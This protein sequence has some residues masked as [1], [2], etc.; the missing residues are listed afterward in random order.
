MSNQNPVIW[1][2][3]AAYPV[4]TAA[5]FERSLRRSN[6]VI[7]FGPTI[8]ETL[9]KNWQL[10]NMKVPVKPHDIVTGPTPDIVD[11]LGIAGRENQPDLLLWVE[12]INGFFPENLHKLNIPK[13]CYFIDSHISLA[14]HLDLA[15][16][17]DF[18]FIAQIEYIEEFKKA[19]IENVY[20]LPL[21]CDPEIHSSGS[22]KKLFDVGFV[23]SLGDP[24]ERRYKL[25]KR[26]ESRYQLAYKRCFWDEMSEHF[27]QSKIVFNNAIRNDLNM[28][29]FEV[30]STGSFLLTD[31]A[32]NSGQSEMFYDGQDLSI[33]NDNDILDKI[34]YY[35]RNENLREKIAQRGQQIVHNAHTYTHR[36]E[37]LLKVSLYN[38]KSTPDPLEWR[39][40]SEQNTSISI[41]VNMTQKPQPQRSFVIPVLDM[42]PASPYN[43]VKLLDDLSEIEGDVI[44]IFNSLEMAQKL[45]D[46]PR[47]DYYAVMNENVG[48]S[49][50][51][52]IGLNMSQTPVTF[53]LNSDLHVEKETVEILDNALNEL[54]GAAIVGPQ[55]S[56]FNYDS[57]EDIQ[58]FDKGSFNYPIVVD[59]VSGF[60][61]A[62]KTEYFNSGILKFDNQYTPCYFEEWDLGLQIKLVNLKSYI[63][64]AVGYEHEWSGSIRALRKIRYMKKEETAGEILERNKK[65]FRQ[66]WD[67]LRKELSDKEDIFTSLWVDSLCKKAERLI[68]FNMTADAAKYFKQALNLY[69]DNKNILSS[70]GVLEYK[71]NNLEEALAYFSKVQ[72]LDPDFQ[73]SGLETETSNVEYEIA[74]TEADDTLKFEEYYENPRPEIQQLIKPGAGKILDVGC[75]KGLMASELKSK[76]DAEVWG[77]EIVRQAA[78]AAEKRLDK[79]L[80]GSIEE[81]LRHLPDSYFDTIIFA[82][83]LEHLTDPTSVLKNIRAKLA[84]NGQIIASIPNVRFWSVVKGL[85]EGN[86]EYQEAGILDNTHL[87]F[88]TKSSIASMFEKAGYSIINL[89]S[90]RVADQDIPQQLLSTMT[91]SGINVS[92]LND[93]SKDFQ[94]LV[95]A[96]SHN[97]N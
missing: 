83:V 55:G 96:V 7:T 84:D 66:K 87:R 39:E 25:L 54:E 22:D 63:V 3:Y 48:V 52:N 56:Y 31:L 85:L 60:F 74:E 95:R 45:K 57:G 50:A 88:F 82:D 44:I 24:N 23:G 15:R 75:G 16:H 21:G 94:Y 59:A 97:K 72:E 42:S 69:P 29:L 43:I 47:I 90:M 32:L 53:I 17:F 46:H 27:S 77:I 51:W 76:L 28:R 78:A 49:R 37:E 33:Y 35:L 92:T 18:V 2:A 62:V 89:Y 34:E 70:L 26:I 71:N 80:S 73:L 61:F 9:I 65:L 64:P 36:L 79:V 38:Q 8:S 12:S 81:N 40:R 41:P 6:R 19:G 67:Y 58:Y 14:R 68:E 86:W 1:L 93:E 4:T 13:A 30:M 5:Y 91:N 11:L 10:E 20:W